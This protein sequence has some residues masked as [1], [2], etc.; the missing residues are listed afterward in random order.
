[1]VVGAFAASFAPTIFNRKQAMTKQE[2]RDAIEFLQR[3]FVGPGDV[4]RLEAAIT[5]LKQEL[6]RRNKK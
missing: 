6:Q 1:V 5:A 2:I 3:L 4:D